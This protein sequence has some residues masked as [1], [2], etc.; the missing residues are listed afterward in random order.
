VTAWALRVVVCSAEGVSGHVVCWQLLCMSCMWF[1]P[2][3]NG[4]LGAFLYDLPC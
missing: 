3:W 4:L 2:L 1:G